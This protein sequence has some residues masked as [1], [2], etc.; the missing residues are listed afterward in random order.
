MASRLELHEEL[1]ALLG[2]R[3]VYFQSPE[4]IE[5]EY[6]C[7]VY[8]LSGIDKNNANN[9][10]Y[11]TDKRYELTYMDYDPD[12][13]LPDKILSHFVKCSFDRMFVSDNLN[14]WVFTLYY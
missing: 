9:K 11:K 4:S 10:A 6:P 5:M 1:C 13:E 2:T 12:S 14:H 7:I 8:A 3:N